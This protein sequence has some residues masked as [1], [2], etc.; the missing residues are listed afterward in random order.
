MA[1][2]YGAIRYYEDTD[3]EKWCPE[4][5]ITK[6]LG[7]R[8]FWDIQQNQEIHKDAD[9]QDKMVERCGYRIWMDIKTLYF[10]II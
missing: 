8:I 9:W 6:T 5:A 4:F 1:S 3:I 7:M 2:K 10:F